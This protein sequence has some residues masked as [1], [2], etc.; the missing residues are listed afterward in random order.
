MTNADLTGAYFDSATLTNAVLTN[1]NLTG[2]YFWDATLTN[3][4]LTNAV[5]KG[6]VF[7]YT[8]Y[9][10]FTAAQL[11]STASYIGGDLTG[12]SLSDNDLTGWNFA[13]KNLTGAIFQCAA[14]TNADLS[15]ANL[16]GAHFYSATLTN[17][18][19][20][21]ADVRGAVELTSSQ[22]FS[23]SSHS[24][25]IY[26]DGT[27]DGLS[28][29]A[30]ERLVVRNN[31]I[32]ITVTGAMNLAEGSELEMRLDESAW[33]STVS[34][35]AGISV[36]LGGTLLL[37]PADGVAGGSL[38]GRTFDLF[39]WNDSPAED[40]RFD[41]VVSMPGYVWDM[42]KLYTTGEVTLTSITLSGDT[43]ADGVVDAADYLAVKQ[44]LGLTGGATL[45]QGNV[46]GD[47]DVDWDDLQMVMTNFGAGSGTSPA[48]TP[49]PA[50]LGLLMFGGAALLRRKRR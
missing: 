24:N 35:Q 15:N 3:A 8:T 16:T 11:Y 1:A 48:T 31:P 44:N 23:T 14:L 21:F 33:D 43:N 36:T 37:T 2:A 28:L 45:A 32:A 34:F 18:D 13:G 46:D 38:L 39:N 47:G 29:K 27:I 20:S 49:E 5:V 40:N 10:G 9:S 19:F 22:W 41:A 26:T 50:T 7:G 17:A 12:I 30:G 6:A 4:D 25:A 42:S